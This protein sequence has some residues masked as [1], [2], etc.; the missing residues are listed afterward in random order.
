MFWFLLFLPLFGA[1]INGLRFQSGRSDLSGWIGTVSC[2]SSFL[3]G[4]FYFFSLKGSKTFSFIPWI[5]VGS[6]NVDFSFNLNPLSLLMVL[7][8]TGVGSLIHFY[9]QEY[10]KE[11]GGK[12]RY[13]SF[14]N[15]FIF[16]MLILVLSDSL[17][18]LFVGWEGVGLCSYLL[19]GFWF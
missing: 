12:T 3:L 10:M 19:I 14:L 1:L 4:C 9:S 16:F 13:F 18:L 17:P 11:D 15:L 8:I 2:F 5:K 7:L 6:L